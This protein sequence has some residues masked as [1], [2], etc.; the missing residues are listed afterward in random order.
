MC[1]ESGGGEPFGF[2]FPT[3]FADGVPMG[4]PMWHLI[5]L[6]D[7]FRPSFEK[8]RDYHVNK[9]FFMPLY[10]LLAELATLDT[11]YVPGA[12][13]HRM[14]MGL[15]LEGP[16]LDTV[17]PMY[18]ANPF[19]TGWKRVL[20][21]HLSP[22]GEKEGE[23][24]EVFLVVLLTGCCIRGWIRMNMCTGAGFFLTIGR[25]FSITA[26]GDERREEVCLE[27]LDM[28]REQAA[29]VLAVASWKEFDAEFR[30]ALEACREA[31]KVYRLCCGALKL[32][33]EAAPPAAPLLVAGGGGGGPVPSCGYSGACHTDGLTPIRYEEPTVSRASLA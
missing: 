1:I 7:F 12:F 4:G 33:R 20:L 8:L 15:C 24:L 32:A 25:R 3:L 27:V 2:P 31:T 30:E 11:T 16:G 10:L 22:G 21:L 29:K 9:V 5:W 18:L 28:I 19:G 13:D 23:C 26:P 14:F 17:N 6:G